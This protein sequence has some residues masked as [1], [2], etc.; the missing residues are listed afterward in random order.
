MGSFIPSQADQEICRN[1]TKRFSGQLV[2]GG[3]GK[4]YIQQLRDHHGREVLEAERCRRVDLAGFEREGTHLLRR[5]RVGARTS[6]TEDGSDDHD[7]EGRRGREAQ[8]V[9]HRVPLQG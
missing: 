5:Q 6:R 9:G 8:G 3:G 1:L 2:P 4:T 7:G